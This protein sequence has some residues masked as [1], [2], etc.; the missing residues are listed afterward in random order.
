MNKKRNLVVVLVSLL[1]LGLVFTGCPDGGGD[2]T[3]EYYQLMGSGAAFWWYTDP[4][5]EDNSIPCVEIRGPAEIAGFYSPEFTWEGIELPTDPPSVTLEDGY[6]MWLYVYRDGKVINIGH[7]PSENSKMKRVF[8]P[9][10]KPEGYE[11]A[12]WHKQ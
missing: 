8:T 4:S 3:P 11:L 5:D 12:S 9:M 7:D 2:N 6:T 1:A 10:E